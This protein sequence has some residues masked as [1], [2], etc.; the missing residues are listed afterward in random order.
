MLTHL[1][2]NKMERFM[3]EL[4]PDAPGAMGNTLRRRIH[5]ELTDNYL[6]VEAP[7]DPSLINTVTPALLK[8]IHPRC[9]KS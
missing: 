8:S 3:R 9:L 2:D 5:H 7:L 6:R 4:R 1:S